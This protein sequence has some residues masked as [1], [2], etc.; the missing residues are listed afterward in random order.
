MHS[1]RK[2]HTPRG[3]PADKGAVVVSFVKMTGAASERWCFGGDEFASSARRLRPR[4]SAAS[5]SA[6]AVVDKATSLSKA[7]AALAVVVPSAEAANAR[8]EDSVRR[9]RTAEERTREEVGVPGRRQQIIPLVLEVGSFE[10]EVMMVDCSIRER[11]LGREEK[12]KGYETAKRRVDDSLP[13]EAGRNLF[14]WR[15]LVTMTV[16]RLLSGASEHLRWGGW[17]F[18]LIMRGKMQGSREGIGPNREQ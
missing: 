11:R 13:P 12:V 7:A 14:P 15:H 2:L 16:P 5:F 3:F 8:K 17:G 6:A 18:V 9:R 1:D 4:A 10:G